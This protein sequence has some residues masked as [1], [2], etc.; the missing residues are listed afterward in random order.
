MWRVLWTE[1]QEALD[2]NGF[3]K[4]GAHIVASMPDADN[5]DRLVQSFNGSEFF[6]RNAYAEPV[7]DWEGL[8]DYL[9][10]E[11]TP[12]AAFRKGFRRI[13]GSHPLG[14]LGG[15]RVR[16]SPDL[17]HMLEHTGRTQPYTRTYAARRPKAVGA[18]AWLFN[19]EGQGVLFDVAETPPPTKSPAMPILRTKLAPL[20]T[21]MLRLFSALP[22]VDVIDAMKTLGP[23]H[24][25]IAERLSISRAQVTNILNGQFGPSRVVVQRVL[26]LTKAA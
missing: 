20:P 18:M 17:K 8:K 4:F 21:P 12:Q 9:L 7:T 22:N 24:Q 10:K 19:T 3:P 16:L 26:E 15:D 23:T 25:S 13:K 1:V 2:R 11:A 6:R 14:D 5:R